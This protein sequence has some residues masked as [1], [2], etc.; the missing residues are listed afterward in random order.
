LRL[1][2]GADDIERM[3]AACAGLPEPSGDYVIDDFLTNL[4][5][6]VV[7][8]QTHTTAVERAIAHFEEQ[9][10][11]EL[12]DVYDL[13]ALMERWPDTEEGNT[14]LALHLWGYRMWTRAHMLRGL[15]EYFLSIGVDDQD[16]LREWARQASFGDFEGQ[17]RGL[18]PAVFQWLI[19]R[20]GVETVKPDVHVHRFVAAVLGRRVSDKDAVEVV[21]A[22]AERLDRSPIRLD[23]AIW[24]AGRSGMTTVDP[25]PVPTVERRPRVAPAKRAAEAPDV[26][27]GVVSFLDDDDGYLRW[28]DAHPDGYVVNSERKPRPS[29]V[30]LHRVECRSIN[31]AHIAGGAEKTWTIAYRKTCADDVAGLTGWVRV[32]VGGGARACGLCRPPL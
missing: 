28:L 19:M 11:P 22:A 26:T 4:V 8:F 23:W 7:D 30:V 18:G 3:V 17:V 1:V 24:E 21:T 6:T 5:A 13:I 16:R 27:D 29:Y 15:V 32:A 20:Q 9:V 2:I 14:A 10:R 12:D 25:G 31:P